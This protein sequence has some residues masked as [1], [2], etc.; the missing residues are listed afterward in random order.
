[1]VIYQSVSMLLHLGESSATGSLG[2]ECLQPSLEVL[3]KLQISSSGISSPSFVHISD[4]QWNRSIQ[5]SNSSHILLNGW[6]FTSTPHV[7]RHFL[8]MS[9]CKRSHLGYF[10]RLSVK[11]S[12]TAA[13]NP[14]ATQTCCTDKGFFFNLSGNDSAD[15]II[16][17]KG[18]TT[19]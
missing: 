3:G 11:G 9:H 16:Y 13:L 18:A 5:T 8:L 15:F 17:I 4:R 19:M 10:G 12:A 14:L 1:M 2:V 6:S 7:G